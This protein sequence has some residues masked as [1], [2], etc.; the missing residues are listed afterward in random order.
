[1]ASGA[2]DAPLKS[3]QIRTLCCQIGFG[4]LADYTSARSSQVETAETDQEALGRPRF[5]A[6]FGR[7]ETEGETACHH[8]RWPEVRLDHGSPTNPVRASAPKR[9]MDRPALVLGKPNGTFN[10][11][12]GSRFRA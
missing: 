3:L 6:V 11:Q 4:N 1:M 5:Q 10:G 9:R 8:T 12:L 2:R 7:V